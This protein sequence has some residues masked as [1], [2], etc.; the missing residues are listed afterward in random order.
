MDCNKKRK[1]GNKLGGF[2]PNIYI[3]TRNKSM[4][5]YRIIY[6]YKT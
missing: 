6:K 1:N 5:T 3:K 2:R 4:I